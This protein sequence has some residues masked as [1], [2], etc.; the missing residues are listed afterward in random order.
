MSLDTEII[1]NMNTILNFILYENP[2][3]PVKFAQST[4]EIIASL[5]H[6]C[7]LAK[8]QKTI[9]EAGIELNK[10]INKLTIKQDEA[11]KDWRKGNYLSLIEN[12]E[13]WRNSNYSYSDLFLFQLEQL[14]PSSSMEASTGG[15]KVKV[16]P[17]S[18]LRF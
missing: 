10:L 14:K 2:N 7:E 4:L 12:L 3:D 16:F 11:Q 8:K 9:D 17:Y 18:T 15:V 1:D 13:A 6:I 5:K